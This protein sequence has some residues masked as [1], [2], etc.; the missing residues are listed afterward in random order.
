MV[1]FLLHLSTRL[2]AET[3]TVLLLDARGMAP[4]LKA[5]EVKVALCMVSAKDN[6]KLYIKCDKDRSSMADLTTSMN[7]LSALSF[8]QLRQFKLFSIFK[9]DPKLNGIYFPGYNL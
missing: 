1:S 8:L 4:A 9:L 3:L 2:V 7:E 6:N 5:V